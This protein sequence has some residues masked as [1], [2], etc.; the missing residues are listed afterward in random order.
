MK[1]K[2]MMTQ[3]EQNALNELGEVCRTNNSEKFPEAFA[4]YANCV[5]DR[6]KTEAANSFST[7]AADNA[8]MAAR[9]ERPLTSAEN[10]YYNAVIGA[11]KSNDPKNAF[12]NL[13]KAMPETII[14]GVI[15]TIKHDHPLLDRITFVSTT[16][17]TKFIL[18]AQPGQT[19]LWGTLGGKI[20]KE[21]DGAFKTFDM[22]LLKLTAFMVV[23]LDFLELGPV[24]LDRY[25]RETLSESIAVALEAKIVDG[26]G[27]GEP[28]G[29]TRDVSS[30]A[31]V[32]GNVY[33]QMTAL[34]L[35][36]LSPASMGALVGKLARDPAAPTKARVVD[37]LIFIVN[38]FAYWGKIMPATT[39]RKPDGGFVRDVLPIP[40]DII[41]S[42]GID[43][44][45][46]ILGI[47]KNYFAGLGVM[48]K[49]GVIT[50]SDEYRFLDDERVYKTRL[51]ANARPLD[52]YSFLYLDITNLDTTAAWPVT[53]VGTV[54]TEEQA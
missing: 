10:A 8:A 49:E 29:M 34:P 5:L 39:F 24:W 48:G 31:S 41:Q 15:G 7:R 26:T 46:A 16:A 23:S 45:H 38:P 22:T 13:D 14:D 6:L 43:A 51:Q 35:T 17:I 33:P 3:E 1:S 52:E 4:K 21:L 19:A 42:A 11:M 12:T 40:A 32:V 30:T 50:Y 2:D 53:I 28:I 44:N 18:N 25:I 9:G 47:P 54:A 36:D 37:D 20:T 27:D